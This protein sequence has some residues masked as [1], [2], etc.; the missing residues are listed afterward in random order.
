[1]SNY[2]PMIDAY[3]QIREELQGLDAEITECWPRKQPEYP[4]IVITELTNSQ[5]QTSGVDELAYQL[6]L[7]AEDRDTLRTLRDRTDEA[8]CKMGWRRTMASPLEENQNGFRRI[9]RY[10]RKVDKRSMRLID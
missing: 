2:F 4:L 7:W 8:M 10:G 6:D 5:T 1:M 3:P 9:F